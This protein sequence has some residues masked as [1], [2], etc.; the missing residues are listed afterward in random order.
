MYP[1]LLKAP[2][3]SAIWGGKRLQNEYGL[4]SLGENSAE[5]WLL[6]CYN[7]FESTVKNGSLTGKTLSEAILS[8]GR[9]CL[10]E[11]AA[12]FSYFPILI[13]L[14]D[15]NDRLSVQVHPDDEYALKNEGQYGKTEMWLVVDCEKNSEIIFGLKEKVTSDEL[16]RRMT[17][18]SLNEICNIVPVKKG[19]VFFI[20]SGTVH[21]I[22]K[23]ILI[24]EIQ[25][26]SD[27]TYRVNDYGRLGADGK[28][29]ELHIE[30]AAS[31]INTSPTALPHSADDG[32]LMLYPFGTVKSLA[33]CKYFT[34]ELLSLNGKAGLC[35]EKSF[36]S[37]V[38]LSGNAVL[39]SSAGIMHL[40][41]G[42]SVFI[43]AKM[44]ATISGAAEIICTHI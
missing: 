35:E 38:V 32:D 30:K 13:K 24:A 18:G 17:D 8:M 36:L 4:E 2:V 33:E 42:D 5:A 40:K 15:A 20:P 10:G 1:L 21:A 27:V 6:S 19:D 14:I 37:L 28:P 31:V 25:Q 23:G 39:S 12:A 34:A 22:G 9:D 7:G 16:S 26:N 44:R 41:K 43:P 3:K 11:N 29:R